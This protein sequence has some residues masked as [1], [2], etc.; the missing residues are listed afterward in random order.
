MS[1]SNDAFSFKALDN[2]NQELI[3]PAGILLCGFSRDEAVKV[4][5]LLRLVVLVEHRVVC[6]TTTMGTWNVDNALQGDDGGELLPIGK[7]PRV[8]LLSGLTDAQVGATLDGYGGTGIERPVFAVA[9]ETNLS[10]TVI[11]LL[12][13][14]LAER[15]AMRSPG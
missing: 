11:Q 15:Q 14:L 8:M 1:E 7:V 13:E 3:G 6:C 12:E 4:E 5:Q 2:A 9:T 10:F